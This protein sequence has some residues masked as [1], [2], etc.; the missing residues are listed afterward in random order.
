MPTDTFFNTE[1]NTC[2]AD[3][4]ELDKEPPAPL[5]NPTSTYKLFTSLYNT[6]DKLER[7]L[8]EFAASASFCVICYRTSNLVKDFGYSTILFAC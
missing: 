1:V 6:F 3:V 7:D 4:V 8:Y 5:S 2:D